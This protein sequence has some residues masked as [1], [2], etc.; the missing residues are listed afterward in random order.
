MRRHG[1]GFGRPANNPDIPPALQNAHEL[2]ER[3]DFSQAAL[4]FEQLAGA[5]EKRFGPRAPFMF[6][7]AGRAR[8]QLNQKNAGLAHFRHG[9][10]LLAQNK[11]YHQLYRTGN[12][13][14]QELKARGLDKEA[15]EISAVIFSHIPAISESP[16]QR[17]PDPSRLILPSHCP[18]CGG[19]VRA[20][21]A[22]WIDSLSAECPYCGS[23]VRVEK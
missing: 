11:N 19:P 23:P 4:A 8:M 5:A 12:R 9:L 21:E 14:V 1:F 22:D 18:S 17:G 15:Q 3:G 7:Q 13:V 16:T 2:M 6:I 10:E 20:D